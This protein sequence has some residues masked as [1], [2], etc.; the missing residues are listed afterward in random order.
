MQEYDLYH[1]WRR[2]AETGSTTDDGRLIGISP[3]QLNTSEG[4]DFE[5]AEFQLDGKI[6]RY[7]RA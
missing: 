2:F 3:G 5:S 4:P 1:L 7:N 6:Y